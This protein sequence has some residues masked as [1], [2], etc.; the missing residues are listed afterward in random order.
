MTN[1]Q[2]LAR[3]L[4]ILVRLAEAPNG[5]GITELAKE[6]DVDKGSM[7]RMLQTLAAYGF[8]EKEPGGRRYILG[9]QIV[10]LSRVVLTRMPLR[11]TAK[12]YLRQLVDSTGTHARRPQ[13]IY[14]AHNYGS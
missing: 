13:T 14:A 7:S 8:A 2:T 12:P 9:P 6:Y 3:G 10:R 1:V 5:L 4:R 11:E